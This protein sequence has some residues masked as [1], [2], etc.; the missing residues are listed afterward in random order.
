[1]GVLGPWKNAPVEEGWC[2]SQDGDAR[3]LE[4]IGYQGQDL[5]LRVS[6]GGP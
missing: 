6:A 3:G 5:G 1:M 2:G 4:K